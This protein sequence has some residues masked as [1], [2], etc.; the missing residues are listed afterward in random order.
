MANREGDSLA[1][2][3]DKHF[4]LHE[5]PAFQ[6]TGDVVI[7]VGDKDAMGVQAVC[8]SIAGQICSDGTRSDLKACL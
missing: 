7:L 3:P 5:A 2:L 4:R 6:I 8:I 1:E